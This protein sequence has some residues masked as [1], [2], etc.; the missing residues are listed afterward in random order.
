MIKS[1]HY[2][3]TEPGFC[4]Q[5]LHCSLQPSIFPR[6]I[7]LDSATLLPSVG[8]INVHGIYP[9]WQNTHKNKK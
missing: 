3:Y 4:S 8:N 1:T 2:S 5:N 6:Q 9:W 7:D